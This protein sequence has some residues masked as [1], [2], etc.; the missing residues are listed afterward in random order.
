[1]TQTDIRKANE[2]AKKKKFGWRIKKGIA[3][4]VTKAFIEGAIE[5]F[6]EIMQDPDETLYYK[7]VDMGGDSD[8]DR[9]DNDAP[10]EDKRPLVV[11]R[12]DRRVSI[13][14]NCTTPSQ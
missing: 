3:A 7:D 9:S 14:S 13:S 8:S 12:K 5:K 6:Y 2:S 11:E 1:M 4:K 10:K